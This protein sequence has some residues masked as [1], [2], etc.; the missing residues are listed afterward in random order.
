M[1]I[2][3]SGH[4]CC[5][6]CV[7]IRVDIKNVHC[8]RV[9][10]P[11]KKQHMRNR[12]QKTPHSMQLHNNE[13]NISRSGVRNPIWNPAN[14]EIRPVADAV[15]TALWCARLKSICFQL[16]SSLNYLPTRRMYQTHIHA[17]SSVNQTPHINYIYTKRHITA[18]ASPHE[19]PH[20]SR[21]RCTTFCSLRVAAGFLPWSAAPNVKTTHSDVISFRLYI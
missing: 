3:F 19:T 13:L 6:Y 21:A 9:I 8:D 15:V 7:F 17:L 12:K 20:S 16:E 10:V 11:D 5:F 2:I 4:Q 1:S 18:A 14:Y